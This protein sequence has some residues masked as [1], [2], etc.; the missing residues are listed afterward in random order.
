MQ[1][2]F[3]IARYPFQLRV[4]SEDGALGAAVQRALDS[5]LRAFRCADFTAIPP[6]NAPVVVETPAGLI[7]FIPSQACHQV[8]IQ[9]Y[10][11][12]NDVAALVDA[13]EP[14]IINHAVRESPGLLWIHGAC[15]HRKGETILLVA[16]SGTGKTSLSLGLL[17]EG[18]RLL[19]DDVIL[20]DPKTRC[21]LPLPR[22]PKVRPPTPEYL[23][24][25]GFDL[26]REAHLFERYVLLPDHRLYR[27]P[28][29]VAVDRLYLLTRSGDGPAQTQKL[30]VTSGII[31]LLER[32]N[33]IAMDPDLT[34]AH[35]LFRGTRFLAMNLGEFERDVASISRRHP[36][37][38]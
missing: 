14:E 19:T 24:A 33:L 16:A 20:I 34:L 15:L 2:D 22:C 21:F 3:Q 9:L 36:G 12:S 10:P 18:F 27:L 32:S 35:D 30:D 7:H 37:Q 1:N 29:P 17:H 8:E 38:N 13:L 11:S 31:G 5:V 23:R 26:A 25:L 4:S 28:L 6:Q